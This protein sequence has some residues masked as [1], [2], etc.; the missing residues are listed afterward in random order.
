[1]AP[2]ADDGFESTLVDRQPSENLVHV[3]NI[4][5]F[6][7]EMCITTEPTE[8][9]EPSTIWKFFQNLAG[10]S[11]TQK[12]ETVNILSGS[13]ASCQCGA[14]KEG[15]HRLRDLCLCRGGWAT[16]TF[17]SPDGASNLTTCLDAHKRL[18]D[19]GAGPLGDR[20]EN[21]CVNFCEICCL[22]QRQ[23]HVSRE[24][25]PA[26]ADLLVQPNLGV[27][28]M[29]A[30]PEDR[31]EAMIVILSGIIQGNYPRDTAT[32]KDDVIGKII[33]EAERG[34]RA[35]AETLIRRFCGR[36]DTVC[37]YFMAHYIKATALLLP[38]DGLELAYKVVDLL[39]ATQPGHNV[40]VRAE[41][42]ANIDIDART[43]LITKLARIATE[44]WAPVSPRFDPPPTAN[45]STANRDQR[46]PS[47]D[48]AMEQALLV[49]LQRLEDYLVSNPPEAYQDRSI[50][51]ARLQ[52][53]KDEVVKEFEEITGMLGDVRMSDALK[54]RYRE[55]FRQLSMEK[56]ALLQVLNSE[57]Q[58][59]LLAAEDSGRGHVD[60]TEPIGD[61]PPTDGPNGD[62]IDHE[63]SLFT[64]RFQ[65]IAKMEEQCD[66]VLKDVNLSKNRHKFL[67]LQKTVCPA[68][69]SILK[70]LGEA[71]KLFSK[72][73]RL[74]SPDITVEKRR[75]LEKCVTDGRSL[76]I[77]WQKLQLLIRKADG[78]HGFSQTSAVSAAAP[79][80]PVEVDTFWG[81]LDGKPFQNLVEWIAELE[82]RVLRHYPGHE[83]KIEHALAHLAP[84]V[85]AILRT[86]K[87][88]TYEELR[89]WLL[90][91]FLNEQDIMDDWVRQLDVVGSSNKH[92]TSCQVG[93]YVTQVRGILKQILEYSTTTV[94]LRKRL[95][96]TR[97]VAHLGKIVLKPLKKPTGKD[98]WDEFSTTVY[99]KLKSDALA[100]GDEVSPEVLLAK[101]EEWLEHV[102][103]TQKHKADLTEEARLGAFRSTSGACEFEKKLQH[104]VQV[105]E[106]DGNDY[107]DV[108]AVAAGILCSGSTDTPTDASGLDKN[109]GR[110]RRR[111]AGKPKA[112]SHVQVQIQ[113]LNPGWG[114]GIPC[115][116]V[117]KGKRQSFIPEASQILVS[118]ESLDQAVAWQGQFRLRCWVC[119][120]NQPGHEFASCEIALAGPNSVRMEALSDPTQGPGYQ[121]FSCLEGTC[122]VSRCLER[123][124][125]GKRGRLSLCTKSTKNTECASCAQ[126]IESDAKKK[127]KIKPFHTIVCCREGHAGLM[128]QSEIISKLKP[129][130]GEGTQ[131]LHVGLV[132]LGPTQPILKSE[133]SSFE[134]SQR[135]Q[136]DKQVKFDPAIPNSSGRGKRPRLKREVDERNLPPH[137][138]DTDMYPDTHVSKIIDTCKGIV[139]N[140]DP[141]TSGVQ[142]IG[143]PGGMAVYFMQMLALGGITILCF[144]DTGAQMS[145]IETS[146]ARELKLRMIDRNGFLMI[147]AG[148]HVTR[149]TD[150]VYELLLGRN[151][152]ENIYRFGVCGMQKLTGQ[153]APCNWKPAHSAIKQEG[154]RLAQEYDSVKHLDRFLQPGEIL[155][156]SSG[157]FRARLLI[158]LKLPDLQPTVM[159]HLPSGILVARTKLY[160]TFNSNVVF[161]GVYQLIDHYA[162]QAYAKFASAYTCDP[163]TAFN[164]HCFTEYIVFRD[165]VYPDIVTMAG[166]DED[167]QWDVE[168]G[169]GV[170]AL[171][172]G[173]NLL[174][175]ATGSG[176]TDSERCLEE[177]YSLQES[178][179]DEDKSEMLRCQLLEPSRNDPNEAG[180]Q[181]CQIARYTDKPQDTANLHEGVPV[182]KLYETPK[183]VVVEPAGHLM[184]YGQPKTT[185][186]LGYG[187]WSMLNTRNGR[188]T[189][190][191]NKLTFNVDP[192]FALIKY[193]EPITTPVDVEIMSF[194]VPADVRQT[195]I[196]PVELN[197]T[198][199][200]DTHWCTK[201]AHRGN[202]MP[203]KPSASGWLSCGA[204]NSG[205]PDWAG[206]R[207]VNSCPTGMFS[208]EVC[209]VSDRTCVSYIAAGQSCLVKPTTAINQAQ[210]GLG[211]VVRHTSTARLVDNRSP[212]RHM[213]RG[214]RMQPWTG[215][216]GPWLRSTDISTRCTPEGGEIQE[217]V[218]QPPC[219]SN[220]YPN[221][222]SPLAVGSP[223]AGDFKRASRCWTR[224]WHV[225]F[226]PFPREIDQLE[227]GR[228]QL[229]VSPPAQHNDRTALCWEA[230]VSGSTMTLL[231]STVSDGTG[232]IPAATVPEK[233][234]IRPHCLEHLAGTSTDN[235][236]FARGSSAEFEQVRILGIE[237]GSRDVDCA[238]DC[239]MVMRPS[240]SVRSGLHNGDIDICVWMSYLGGP[241]GKHSKEL[242]SMDCK[243][244]PGISNYLQLV[245]RPRYVQGKSDPGQVENAGQVAHNPRKLR[246]KV[247]R[248]PIMAASEPFFWGGSSHL[249]GISLIEIETYHCRYQSKKLAIFIFRTRTQSV[250]SVLV[251]PQVKSQY[252]LTHLENLSSKIKNMFEQRHYHDRVNI[253]QVKPANIMLRTLL[254]I[255]M[256]LKS[257]CKF[258]PIAV[259]NVHKLT[260]IN[261]VTD[262]CT[263]S[264]GVYSRY[265]RHSMLG[266]TMTSRPIRPI[267]RRGPSPSFRAIQIDEFGPFFGHTMDNFDEL[268][269]MFSIIT[270]TCVTTHAV[271]IWMVETREVSTLVRAIYQHYYIYGYPVITYVAWTGEVRRAHYKSNSIT[272]HSQLMAVYRI[273]PVWEAIRRWV[274]NHSLLLTEESR[275]DLRTGR[276]V[277]ASLYRFSPQD[278]HVER[279]I[280]SA[281]LQAEFNGQDPDLVVGMTRCDWLDHISEIPYP[282]PIRS[283][284]CIRTNEPKL[285][286]LVLFMHYVKYVSVDQF[287]DVTKYQGIWRSGRIC[288]IEDNSTAVPKYYIS[289]LRTTGR[290][291]RKP[292]DWAISRHVTCRVLQEIHPIASVDEI[293]SL[294]MQW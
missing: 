102:K 285:G 155:P 44:G 156:P 278:V 17:S 284:Y 33:V 159:F 15:T 71:V 199:S 244:L 231:W 206:I 63:V 40:T 21:G 86:H 7:S 14:M 137:Y 10:S 264:A 129:L 221:A 61:G 104:L 281:K 286:D 205:I 270:I 89:A 37:E 177:V 60:P 242:S 4:R 5:F 6:Q 228:F 200:L 20:D 73:L 39:D 220:V 225:L 54:L 268:P 185:P 19:S 30:I 230:I 12:I 72:W 66:T 158:G 131:R 241:L 197:R 243:R 28:A 182:S 132:Q 227:D 143:E 247:F 233:S 217:I 250:K 79:P 204:I 174:T 251:Q 135:T 222:S 94:E 179:E 80:T 47:Q 3:T 172:H 43:A 109:A 76:Q 163:Y 256:Q 266:K 133:F 139:T 254:S 265:K 293:Q 83:D 90:E 50:G 275:D 105:L 288:R 211:T 69:T 103:M 140:F 224:S 261:Q 120:N 32:L 98:Q 118:Q 65:T 84:G 78:R 29:V 274:V 70:D 117:T 53:V 253:G 184:S 22:F 161:G 38:Q 164:R 232:L 46:I 189:R 24:N 240:D 292:A 8:D 258:K 141:D 115:Y 178:E 51:L 87:P 210:I 190:Q 260:D 142:V 203:P 291:Y 166:Q 68:G 282:R 160:D 42:M 167:E 100:T 279:I 263:V 186:V 122:F 144:Y 152:G 280:T 215:D 31:L 52:S 187:T 219:L 252:S 92:M 64:A 36:T 238:M 112:F 239:E 249:A 290:G 134:A 216:L 272:T 165:S 149:T 175:A 58:K 99:A 168:T 93:L 138:V 75:S 110:R 57:T 27:E 130:Y 128:N 145:L 88:S 287:A 169:E 196:S 150:G 13:G 45:H 236:E 257:L 259:R 77:R 26:I 269:M 136:T 294:T 180:S 188:A 41:L 201:L 59:A 207:D 154:E 193:S 181:D 234:V 55:Y 248:M 289:Y 267:L 116:Q 48:K 11:Q 56:D 97:S 96:T 67:N 114:A 283:G 212:G 214:R 25:P 176:E 273:S 170:G 82:D 246:L 35:G 235:G 85:V 277:I 2:A 245:A 223:L 119:P 213:P 183:T 95:F 123:A 209:N 34:I 49:L 255:D 74:A 107:D 146:L 191:S 162:T 106:E 101:V 126:E 18:H 108:V 91:H 121:C 202:R 271:N 124:K 173:D 153:M 195:I 111:T 218:E 62:E 198:T 262:G 151:Q 148:N 9:G 127:G 1:M 192:L 208:V 171:A 113:A 276:D 229:G 125:S 237:P 194:Y 16:I 157:G 226:P 147:G 81:Q 23:V